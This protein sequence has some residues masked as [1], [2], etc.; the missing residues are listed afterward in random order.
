MSAA[1]ILS[2]WNGCVHTA[3][4]H[5]E[6]EN[7]HRAV[8]GKELCRIPLSEPQSDMPIDVLVAI[9]RFRGKMQ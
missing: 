4:D 7:R 9:L 8:L 2:S 5:S 3:I 6:V 1:L